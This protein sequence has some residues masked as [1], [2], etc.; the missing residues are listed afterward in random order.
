MPSKVKLASASIIVSLSLLT[1]S[2]L[3]LLVPKFSKLTWVIA[4]VLPIKETSNSVVPITTGSVL[5]KNTKDLPLLTVPSSTTVKAP[6]FNFAGV[7]A[8]VALVRTQGVL[9]VPTVDNW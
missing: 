6:A 3:L 5:G 1:V 8:S 7:S 4:L 2:I 9:P